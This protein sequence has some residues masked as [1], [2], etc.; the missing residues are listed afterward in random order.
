MRQRSSFQS[1][2]A[3][4]FA[5]VVV[6]GLFVPTTVGCKNC[7]KWLSLPAPNPLEVAPGAVPSILD[8]TSK[9]GCP[10]AIGTRHLVACGNYTFLNDDDKEFQQDTCAY[11][12]DPALIDPQ[13]DPQQ[14]SESHD[15]G[16]PCSFDLQDD[17]TRCIIAPNGILTCRQ[18]DCR[19]T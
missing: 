1:L 18:L 2:V 7:E 17:D 8:C 13:T 16:Y 4:A 6:G 14:V 19:P 12:L 11:E 10:P 15:C 5:L 9:G 3:S